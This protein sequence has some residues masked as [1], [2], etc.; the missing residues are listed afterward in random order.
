MK[1]IRLFGIALL[2][3]LMSVSFSACGSDDDG[4]QTSSSPLI[5]TWEKTNGNGDYYILEFKADGSYLENAVLELYNSSDSLVDTW[6]TG[7]EA[8]QLFLYSGRHVLK[9]N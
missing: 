2:T 6:T 9:E 7:N 1:T 8:H 3:V 5:G 4:P